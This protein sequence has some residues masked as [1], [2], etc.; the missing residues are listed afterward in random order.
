MAF[1][2]ALAGKGGTGKTTTAALIVRALDEL[3]ARSILAVDADPNAPAG[4][5][6]VVNLEGPVAYDQIPARRVATTTY[7]GPAPGL[8]R[9]RD[10]LRAWAMTHGGDAT[11]RPYEEYLSGIPNMLADDAKFTVVWPLKN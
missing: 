4:E 1:T 5:K 11:D 3:G 2:I 7:T 6:L 9:A 10:V 8:P